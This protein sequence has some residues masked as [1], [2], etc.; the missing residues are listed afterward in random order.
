MLRN[1]PLPRPGQGRGGG[2]RSGLPTAALLRSPCWSPS[3][4]PACWPPWRSPCW[5]SSWRAIAGTAATTPA[6]RATR[7]AT[8]A[9]CLRTSRRV[10]YCGAGGALL[11][12]CRVIFYAFVSFFSMFWDKLLV[13]QWSCKV[14]QKCGFP[15]VFQTNNWLSFPIFVCPKIAK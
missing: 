7:A 11:A 13:E 2:A 15:E 5:G 10:P 4:C 6:P 12:G 1:L 3:R 8:S 9:S 14:P